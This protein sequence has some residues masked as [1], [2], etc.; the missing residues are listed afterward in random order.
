MA[1]FAFENLAA[2]ELLAVRHP[3]KIDSSRVMDRLGMHY[4]GLEAWYGTS[5]ATHVLSREE[6]QRRPL[7]PGEA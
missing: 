4:R 3:D 1:A 7:L 5:L 2:A 6:W